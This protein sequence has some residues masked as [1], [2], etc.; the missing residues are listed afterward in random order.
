MK[1]IWSVTRYSADKTLFFESYGDVVT[2]VLNTFLGE[3]EIPSEDAVCGQTKMGFAVKLPDGRRD[4]IQINAVP[5][6]TSPTKI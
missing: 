6:L 2:S 4:W 5:I 3:H 1:F